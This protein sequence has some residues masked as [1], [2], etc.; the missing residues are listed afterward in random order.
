MTQSTTFNTPNYLGILHLLKPA[1]APFYSMIGA[2]AATAS[3]D[4]EWTLG[5]RTR[6]GSQA[7]VALEGATVTP[8]GGTRSAGSNVCQ[9]VQEGYEITYTK[10][11]ATG[12]H[13]GLNILGDASVMDEKSYQA[14]LKLAKIKEDLEWSFLHGAYAKPADNATPR[15][16]RGVLTAATTNVVN[17]GTTITLTSAEADDETFTANAAHGLAVNDEIELTAVTGGTGLTA[18]TTYFVKTVPS[19]TTFTVAATIGGATVAFS[20]DV[21]AGTFVKKGALTT[22]RFNKLLRTMVGNGAPMDDLVV[23][24]NS[25]NKQKITNL[26]GYAPADRSVGGLAIDTIETDFAR[27]GVV[28]DR[29]VDADTLGVINTGVCRPRVLPI[30]GKGFL[31]EEQ[32]GKTASADSYQIY[33][34]IGLEYGPEDWHGQ[35]NNLTTDEVVA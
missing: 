23:V 30:P 35:I 24:V 26:Y 5:D 9:I 1:E 27:L 8:S 2:K 7:N 14:M 11:A 29:F 3:K 31:F 12:N 10:M 33:G 17:A 22:A 21:S 16:T 28:Y 32:M 25:F 15:K 4:F 19:S 20:T 34:E 18:G 6:G 13:D